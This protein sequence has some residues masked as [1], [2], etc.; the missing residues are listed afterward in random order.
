MAEVT[1]ITADKALEIWNDSITDGEIDAFGQLILKKRGGDEINAGSLVSP[2]VAIDAVYPIGSIYINTSN[3]DPADLFGVGEWTRFANGRVLVGVDEGQTE[4]DQPL[5]TGGSKSVTL[6]LAQIP[7]HTHG[8]SHDHDLSASY[9]MGAVGAGSGERMSS[10]TFSSS[11]SEK[12]TGSTA[13]SSKTNTD[14]AGGSGGSTAA[15]T[16][17]QPYITVYMWR[18]TA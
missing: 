3:A 4:F 13:G 7:P 1:G 15:H 17:L 14:S 11:G 8:M 12:R 6:S 5:E 10:W 2:V 9:N 18:R 16:N